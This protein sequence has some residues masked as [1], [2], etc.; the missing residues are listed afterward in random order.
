ME[1]KKE[2][3]CAKSGCGLKCSCCTC[4]AVRTALTLL[5]GAAIGFFLGR[6]CGGGG[7]GRAHCP[8][9]G[10]AMGAQAGAPGAGAAH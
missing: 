7:G 1:E 10:H 6:G 8:M 2:G 3:A 5:V 9:S 4:K